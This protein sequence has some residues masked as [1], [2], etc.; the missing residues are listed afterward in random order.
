MIM[1]QSYRQYGGFFWFGFTSDW[2]KILYYHFFALYFLISEKGFGLSRLSFIFTRRK[3]NS[4][5]KGRWK[6]EN[7]GDF[8]INW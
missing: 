6:R 7:I 5:E 8:I 4:I 1:A 3:V 2:F